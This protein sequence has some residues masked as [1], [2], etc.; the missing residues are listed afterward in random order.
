[1]NVWCALVIHAMRSSYVG[2]V[3]RKLFGQGWAGR[4]CRISL[5]FK[6]TNEKRPSSFADHFDYAPNP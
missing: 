6:R 5:M 4:L 2:Q 1:V 3:L